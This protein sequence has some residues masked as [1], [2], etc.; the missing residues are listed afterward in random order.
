MNQNNKM[1][2]VVIILISG[3]RTSQLTTR[4]VLLLKFKP[5]HIWRKAIFSCEDF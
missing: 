1:V 3:A 5:V 2:F 4:G